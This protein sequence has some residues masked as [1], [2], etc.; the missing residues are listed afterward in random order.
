[1]LSQEKI[2]RH[3]KNFPVRED[4]VVDILSG[5]T[6]VGKNWVAER[7]KNSHQFLIPTTSRSPGSDERHGVNYYFI[8]KQEY[9]RALLKGEF[10]TTFTMGRHYYGYRGIEF[11]KITSQ[12]YTPLAII[13]YKVLDPFLEKFPNSR[14]YFM[15]PPFSQR[16]LELLK[17]RMLSR[18][19]WQFE[20]RWKD[21]LEQMQAMYV[22]K[23]DLLEKYP[24]SKLY[25]ITDDRS[26]LSL[27]RELKTHHP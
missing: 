2:K 15:F 8:S 14:I 6:A 26:A 11:E 3:L 16:G 19:V 24:N 22:T 27:I 9:E 1:M 10:V 12:K 18:T 20:A 25:A 23:P 4:I 17:R 7:L 13:Y 21:T 5:P